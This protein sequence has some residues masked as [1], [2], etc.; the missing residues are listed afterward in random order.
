MIVPAM[1]GNFLAIEGLVT[2]GD[3]AATAQAIRASEGLFRA[4][5]LALMAVVVLVSRHIADRTPP[6]AQRKP[7][8]PSPCTVSSTP[9]SVP[10]KTVSV[11][12]R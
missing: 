2:H 7:N 6:Q 12:S 8:P 10:K 1:L 4:G 3:P 9:G 11:P 5:I